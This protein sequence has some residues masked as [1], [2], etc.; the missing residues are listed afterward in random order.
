VVEE[1]GRFLDG[2]PLRFALTAADVARM[3]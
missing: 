2:E 3:G 1:I